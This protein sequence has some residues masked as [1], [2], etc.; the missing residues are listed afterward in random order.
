MSQHVRFCLCSVTQRCLHSISLRA[1]F[2][3]Y[4]LHYT[5]C[6]P[7]ITQLVRYF[8]YVCEGYVREP[9]T[10]VIVR[11]DTTTKSPRTKTP[12]CSPCIKHPG[13]R[14]IIYELLTELSISQSPCQRHTSRHPGV[15][16]QSLAVTSLVLWFY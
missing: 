15:T 12:A 5:R 9:G 7:Y 14:S 11:Y 4:R 10:L 6:L 16:H 3:V 1:E 13:L 2:C 8:V